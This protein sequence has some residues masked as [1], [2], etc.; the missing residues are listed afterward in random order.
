MHFVLQGYIESNLMQNCFCTQ[1]NLPSYLQ[2]ERPKYVDSKSYYFP[3]ILMFCTT[4]YK[5]C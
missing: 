2:K 3:C 4:A 1:E 5:P